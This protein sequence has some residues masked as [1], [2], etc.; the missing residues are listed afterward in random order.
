VLVSVEELP[1]RSHPTEEVRAFQDKDFRATLSQH[2]RGNQT[3]VTCPDDD[4][5]IVRHADSSGD[6]LQ[7]EGTMSHVTYLRQW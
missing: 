6:D 1:G 5:V 2:I 7:T 3:I 4:R